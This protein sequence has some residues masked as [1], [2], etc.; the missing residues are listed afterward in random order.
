[1]A[2]AARHEIAARHALAP[3]ILSRSHRRDFGGSIHIV[4]SAEDNVASRRSLIYG[5]RDW[6]THAAELVLDLLRR[7]LQGVG[8]AELTDFER[9]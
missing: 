2:Q 3:L 9:A 7:Y 8:V 4:I 5:G 1:V 6:A